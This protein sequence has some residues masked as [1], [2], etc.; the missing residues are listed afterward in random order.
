[1][2]YTIGKTELYEQYFKERR[3]VKKQGRTKDYPGGS[4]WQTREEAEK[5][6]SKG[7]SVYGV[8]A[9]WERDTTYS[10]AVIDDMKKIIVKMYNRYN[11]LRIAKNRLDLPV[12]IFDENLK[13]YCIELQNLLNEIRKAKCD[14]KCKTW[15][16]FEEE[17]EKIDKRYC[18]IFR[19]FVIKHSTNNKKFIEKLGI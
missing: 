14:S 13:V 12:L 18:N 11:E 2:I 4:V 3:T 5:C 6:C 15:K 8:E 9:D 1:M 10:D 16:Y 7:Y 19:D 17:K